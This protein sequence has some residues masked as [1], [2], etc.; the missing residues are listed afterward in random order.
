[1]Q[2][3]L[4]GWITPEGNHRGIPVNELKVNPAF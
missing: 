1:V 2:L 4:I 3:S